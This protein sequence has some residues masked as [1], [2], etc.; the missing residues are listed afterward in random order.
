ERAKALEATNECSIFAI[1]DVLNDAAWFGKASG[2]LATEIYGRGAPE[3]IYWTSHGTI[4]GTNHRNAQGLRDVLGLF[5]DKGD[6]TARTIVK[7]RGIDAVLV[8]ASHPYD[9]MTDDRST[10]YRRLVDRRGPDWLRLKP[11][12]EGIRSGYLLYMVDRER[13]QAS[14]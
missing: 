1:R 9:I 10:L 8:C 7:T 14:R 6:E 11:W 3:I 12:P 5:F 13:L 2:I 4:F